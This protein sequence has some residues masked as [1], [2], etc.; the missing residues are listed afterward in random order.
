MGTDIPLLSPLELFFAAA[1]MCVAASI[2]IVMS[3]GIHRTFLIAAIRLIIQLL[4]VAYIL[5][6]VFESNSAFIILVVM[7]VMISAASYEV[8]ARQSNRKARRFKMNFSILTVSSL[9]V[10]SIGILS[11]LNTGG[12][13]LD[14]QHIIPIFGIILGAAMN[15]TALTLN[16]YVRDLSQGQNIIEARLSLGH[17]FRSATE[18]ISKNSAISGSIPLINQ[19]AGAG[20]ITLP[21]IMSGQ[22]LV[23]QS[24][25]QA[26][27]YQIFLM[28]LLA[29]VTIVCVSLSLWLFP[30]FISDKRHR[31]RLERIL[32]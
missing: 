17:S 7:I 1:L 11:L 4:L 25:I 10:G 27:F 2:T 15:S 20:I 8:G 32:D 3:M 31:L 24:P 13:T 29:L 18:D 5:R 14:A 30:R 9:G 23:G 26:A 28:S 12:N 22:L 6:F 16:C 21:G 19:M